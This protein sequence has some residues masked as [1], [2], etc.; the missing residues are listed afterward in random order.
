MAI[1]PESEGSDAGARQIPLAEANKAASS[2]AECF[3]DDDVARYYLQVSDSTRPLTASEA[4]LN[5]QIY[6]ALTI[7]HCCSGLVISAGP[8]HD[9]VSLW[10]PPNSSD[11]TWK[12]Y[13]KSGLWLLWLRL[14]KE[15]RARFFGSWETLEEGMTSIMGDRAAITWTLT[16]LGTIKSSRGKGYAT[17]AM[18]YGLALAD[19]QNQPTYV[20]CF[21]YNVSFYERFGFKKQSTLSLDRAQVPIILQTMVREP[22]GG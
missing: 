15:G 6:E 9:C 14:G 12:T 20:E 7:A 21:E 13:W 4:S 11:W 1:P 5:Y 3:S 2:L 18:K 16:D 17:K 22:G 19:A 10:L 8:S